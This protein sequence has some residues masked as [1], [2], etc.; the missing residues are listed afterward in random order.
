MLYD[1]TKLEEE[2]RS[3]KRIQIVLNDAVVTV[4]TQNNMHEERIENLF[5]YLHYIICNQIVEDCRNNGYLVLHGAGIEYC[6][7]TIVLMGAKSSGKTTLMLRCLQD[8]AV[9]LGD[10][11][12]LIKDGNIKPLLMPVRMKQTTNIFLEDR[13]IHFPVIDLP[14]GI[15]P[16]KRCIEWS[17]IHRASL[18]LE[19]PVK[20][21]FSLHESYG[22]GV[23]Q[24]SKE[25]LIKN[26]FQ[27]ARNASSFSAI[28][29]LAS[30]QDLKSFSIDFDFVWSEFQNMIETSASNMH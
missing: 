22:V 29:N 12:L 20:Y 23:H 27:N 6:G 26:L 14:D 24:M 18:S 7:S 4:Q 19:Y 9:Y 5:N 13:N 30:H 11:C 21:I 25:E 17:S 8:G 15:D 3:I 16:K 10:E 28:L 1:E 2:K